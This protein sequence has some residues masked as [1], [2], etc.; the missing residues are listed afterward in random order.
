MTEHDTDDSST[1]HTDDSSTLHTE[2]LLDAVQQGIEV[3]ADLRT[4]LNEVQEELKFAMSIIRRQQADL[5]EFREMKPKLDALIASM[6]PT[7]EI[8][9]E[10]VQ[11]ETSVKVTE[12]EVPKV[13]S[14]A[15]KSRKIIPHYEAKLQFT[16]DFLKT[17]CQKTGDGKIKSK[18]FDNILSR[19]SLNEI[20]IKLSEVKRLMEDSGYGQ[21]P[22]KDGETHYRIIIRP[23][24]SFIPSVGVNIPSTTRTEITV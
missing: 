10:E 7:K 20:P 12:V 2:I 3:V 6:D 8:I 14:S 11:T 23:K 13:D 19:H 21:F 17:H 16:Q 4:Q 24:I 15:T 1:L 18:K 5:D 22:G 9:S